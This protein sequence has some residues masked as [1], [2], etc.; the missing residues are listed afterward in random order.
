MILRCDFH[1]HSCLS[2]CGSLE[3]SP[4]AIAR[5]AKAAG[6]DAIA[7]TDH[8]SALNAPAFAAACRREGLH[9]LYGTEANTLEEIHCLAL[10]DSPEAAV[11]FGNELYDHLP[12][13]RNIP[14]KLGD[15][16]VVDEH[17]VVLQQVDKF[18]INATDIP[19]SALPA[20]VEAA[21]GLFIPAHVDRP[22]CGV[23]AKLGRLPPETGSVLGITRF[24]VREMQQQ[25]A[26]T[27][28]L[29]T[30]SDAHHLADIG[31]AHTRIDAEAFSLSAIREA[32]Q[33]G[34]AET[35][36]PEPPSP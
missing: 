27:H 29:V 24:R 9:A 36:V 14:E 19:Y 28:T 20:R 1:I 12:D 11:A 32:L 26:A 16:V 10:F 33:N 22:G 17:D 15:Q 5:T 21:G 2:P 31:R 3:M 8:N 30:F 4:A 13:F 23:F 7:I 18:L 34:R 6:L 35:V 25:F